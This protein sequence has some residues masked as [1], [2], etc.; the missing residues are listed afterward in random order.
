MR[1]SLDYIYKIQKELS[2]LR[3]ISSLLGWDQLTYMPRDG[4]KVRSKQSSLISKKIHKKIV[5]DKLWANINKL[6]KPNNFENLSEVD[7]KVVE[8]LK[9][10]VEK[11]RKIPSKLVEEL[12]EATTVA[13]EAWEKARKKDDFS[14]FSP[15]FSRIIELKKEYC[16]Y[17]DIPGHIYNS[18]LDDYEEGMTT[19]KIRGEFKN[20]KGNILKILDKIDKTTGNYSHGK[21]GCTKLSSGEQKKI[22]NFVIEKMGLD[23]NKTRFDS[24]THPFTTSLDYNDVRIT[25][26]F[27]KGKPL[28][29]LFSTIHEAGHALYELGLPQ[30]QYVDTVISDSASIG[31]H[32]S[33]SR[34]WENMI[35]KSKP[36]WKFM[37]PK[38]KKMRI[39]PFK[40]PDIEEIYKIIN[41]VRPSLIRVEADE[42]TYNLHVI[43]R[44]EIEV[45]LLEEKIEVNDIPQLW[46]EKI[47]E[48]L[49]IMPTTYQEGCLQDMHW[50]QGALGYFPTYT[51]G[52][53]YSSQ[54]YNALVKD[55]PEVEERVKKGDFN[56]IVEWLNN[57][58]H[59]K[60]RLLESEEIMKNICGEGLDSN[61]FIS[62]LKEK[63]Y[64]IYKI[65]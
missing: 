54:L 14:I 30:N 52:T 20:L 51:I 23:K 46:N 56:K 59:C 29:S 15:H 53:I 43:F 5:S 6:K 60:G 3:G 41:R 47:Q 22:C 39:L 50:S 17:V 28:F 7:K 4:I 35:G 1:K 13:Y 18:L 21:T 33:Q 12:T 44:F 24:S 42:L 55:I 48:N 45:G 11:S 32:E 40:K 8:R 62:Y 49:G 38:M 27:K 61:T 57:K 31:L 10:D 64:D 16:D 36:F 34:F 26:N 63:Y 9:K 25:T 58:I 37:L 19:K 65:N 2:V